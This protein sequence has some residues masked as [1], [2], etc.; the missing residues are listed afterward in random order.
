MVDLNLDSSPIRTL[1]QLFFKHG[2]STWLSVPIFGGSFNSSCALHSKIMCLHI[3]MVSNHVN[4]IYCNFISM[5]YIDRNVCVLAYD[6]NHSLQG[7]PIE[8]Q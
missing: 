7:T 5:K 1:L 2:G 6:E 4:V 8:K 3:L